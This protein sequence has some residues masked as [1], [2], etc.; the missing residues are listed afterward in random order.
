MAGSDLY[1][2]TLEVV[3]LKAL[4]GQSMHGYA[5][6]LWIRRNSANVLDVKEGVLYP[7]LH[8]VERK[9]WV[10]ARWGKTDT[11]RRAKFYALSDLGRAHLEAE[12]ARLT[13]YSEAVL[14]LLG[15]A[16]G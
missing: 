12:S 9:G 2:G 16:E 1:T 14:A 3:V 8:R 4:S 10:R 7:A 6:G 11:G 15:H 5:I 13:E